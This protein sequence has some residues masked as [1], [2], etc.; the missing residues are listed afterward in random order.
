[1]STASSNSSGTNRSD[2]SFQSSATRRSRVLEGYRRA[3]RDYERTWEDL[4][5]GMNPS[6]IQTHTAQSTN[7][8]LLAGSYSGSGSYAGSYAG[9]VSDAGSRA[10]D[11]ASSRASARNISRSSGGS[12]VQLVRGRSRSPGSDSTITA[13]RMRQQVPRPRPPP[14]RPIPVYHQD[15]NDPG[16]FL[17]VPRPPQREQWHI[18]ADNYNGAAWAVHRKS[19]LETGAIPPFYP[20]KWVNGESFGNAAKDSRRKEIPLTSKRFPYIFTPNIPC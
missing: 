14:D 6:T 15:P 11:R 5:G 17:N 7:Y 12:S 16:R 19:E 9:S 18:P 10:E 2:R 20:D 3:N 13:H 8:F 1:M 4:F